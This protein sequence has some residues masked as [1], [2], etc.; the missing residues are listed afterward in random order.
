MIIHE[1]ECVGCQLP[2]IY[3]SCPYYDVKR[4]VCDECGEEATLYEFNGQEL[5][6]ECIAK[7]LIVVEG[8]ECYY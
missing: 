8:S 4:F 2:C 7:Q 3:S 1:N 6:I 5:C